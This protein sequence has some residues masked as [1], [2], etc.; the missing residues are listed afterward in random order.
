MASGS[1]WNW[2][3]SLGHS[4]LQQTSP[5]TKSNAQLSQATKTWDKQGCNDSQTRLAACWDQLAR[6]E[7]TFSTPLSCLLAVQCVPGAQLCE[8]SPMLAWA[9]VMQVSLSHFC[10]CKLPLT[11][12]PVGNPNKTRL[13]TKLEF[14]SMHSLVWHGLWFWGE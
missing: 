12:I 13:F 11:H 1:P 2:P 10:F 8:L 14:G 4:L 6:L 5:A 7:R 9:L 3:D